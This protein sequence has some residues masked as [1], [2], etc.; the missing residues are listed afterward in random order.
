MN[1]SLIYR[2]AESHDFARSHALSLYSIHAIYTYIPK[3]ACTLFRWSLA[4]SNGYCLELSDL[5]F[6]HANN[7]TFVASLDNLLKSTLTFVVL[8]CPFSRLASAFLDKGTRGTLRLPREVD[9]LGDL[10][11]V[12]FCKILSGENPSQFNH[13]FRPQIDFLIFNEYD[14][15]FAIE[16]IDYALAVLALE[17]F[18]ISNILADLD[19]TSLRYERLNGDFS[20]TPLS[21]ITYM[22]S[23]NTLPS[24]RALYDENSYH[25]IKEIF[26]QDIDFYVGKFGSKHIMPL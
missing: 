16:D 6:V 8:R 14:Y 26:S 11:F 13:H 23:C 2:S 15:Y 21:E 22:K 5:D 25:L 7:K 18:D 1:R 12:E 9:N 17:G 3:N 24:N 19:H 20:K 4:K 10:N